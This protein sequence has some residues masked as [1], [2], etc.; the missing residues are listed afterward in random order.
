MK[1]RDPLLSILAYY[2]THDRLVTEYTTVEGQQRNISDLE[3]S[4]LPYIFFSFI[5]PLENIVQSYHLNA[6]C[7]NAN[8]CLVVFTSIVPLQLN[9]ELNNSQ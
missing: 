6:I 3:T 2:F 9:D 5:I 1:Y 7:K 4:I 8:F